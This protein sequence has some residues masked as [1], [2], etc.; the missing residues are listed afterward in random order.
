MKWPS[1][2]K[3]KRKK[4]LNQNSILRKKNLIVLDF[5]FVGK[6]RCSFSRWASVWAQKL[7]KKAKKY[8]EGRKRDLVSELS[9]F[10]KNDYEKNIYS[11]HEEENGA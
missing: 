11:T 2:S 3:K 9:E 5:S 4:Y 1:F 10:K 7:T 8:E 6:S